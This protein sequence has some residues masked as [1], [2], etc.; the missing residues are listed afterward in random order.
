MSQPITRIRATNFRS[1]A[2]VDVTFGPLTVLIGP[3]GAGK[4]NLLKVLQFLATT[5]R[6]DLVDAVNQWGGFTHVQRQSGRRGSVTLEV[7]GLVTANASWNAPDAYKLTVSEA[8]GRLTRTEEFSFKRTSGGGRRKTIRGSGANVV[9]SG[10][11]RGEV[12]R[13]L[14]NAQTTALATL[15]RL[16]N[17]DG[18]LGIRDFAAMLQ[19][20]RI[21]DP[22]VVA[23]RMP[24]S[25]YGGQLAEDASNLADALHTLS[26]KDE[27]AWQALKHDVARCL[28]G[29]EDVRFSAIGGS[30]RSVVV[31]LIE[32]G[33]DAPIELRDASFGT[34]RLLA[35]LCLLHDPEPPQFVAVEEIDHGLHPYALDILADRLR[36]ASQRTQL[37]VATHSP[38][39]VNRL[40]PEEMVICER[41]P[42][43]GASIIPALSDMEITSALEGFDGRAG[44][45]WFAG[46]LGG[47][48][49]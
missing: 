32:S 48:P 31:E 22:D 28:P 47:V 33:L 45:L 38:T 17:E 25:Q 12:T 41:D 19:G 20:I 15:P 23:A 43:T 11:G 26:R 44:E 37:V 40:R 5:A 24:A 46:A 14:A 6:F 39:F 27:D 3:N 29:L 10:D 2:D 9:I 16:S 8:R 49:E 34:V 35:L 4:S 36:A 18:G 21:F 13:K 1:L 42:E 7:E 30:G